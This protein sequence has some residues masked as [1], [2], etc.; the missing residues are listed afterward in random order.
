MLEQ[1]PNF[2][3]PPV[4]STGRV[5]DSRIPK[6]WQIQDFPWGG[7]TGVDSRGGYVSKI[8]YVETKESGHLG[9]LRSAN[10]KF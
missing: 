3:A 6:Q 1:F 8:L 10:A 9:S 7:G 2:E 4:D 5:E